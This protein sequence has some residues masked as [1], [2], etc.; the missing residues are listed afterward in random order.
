M[1]DNGDH[2]CR[3]GVSAGEI[4]GRA[5]PKCARAEEF[6]PTKQL[7]SLSTFNLNLYRPS[8]ACVG[9]KTK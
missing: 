5:P 2:Y 4:K 1:S 9:K 7:D 6:A 3:L 8:H